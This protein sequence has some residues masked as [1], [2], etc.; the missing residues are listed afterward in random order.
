VFHRTIYSHAV[1]IVY[2]YYKKSLGVYKLPNLEK[3]RRLQVS[4]Y[5]EERVAAE[6]RELFDQGCRRLWTSVWTIV[7]AG[8]VDGFICYL[9]ALRFES[10]DRA[11]RSAGRHANAS[12]SWT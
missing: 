5:R 12:L 4:P 11:G 3:L 8:C 2:S 9:S 6:R 1:G 10:C 7:L